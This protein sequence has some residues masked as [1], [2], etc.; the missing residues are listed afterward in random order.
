MKGPLQSLYTIIIRLPSFIISMTWRKSR[1]IAKHYPQSDWHILRLTTTMMGLYLVMYHKWDFTKLGFNT[2]SSTSSV[3]LLFSKTGGTPSQEICTA[4]CQGNS[5]VCTLLMNF[6]HLWRSFNNLVKSIQTVSYDPLSNY[7][8]QV[9]IAFL[10]WWT[11]W[12]YSWRRKRQP[13]WIS[14]DGLV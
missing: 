3:L 14:D 4:L 13:H 2:S 1:I 11:Y 10:S 8:R 12:H 6:I 9:A 5:I 7:S